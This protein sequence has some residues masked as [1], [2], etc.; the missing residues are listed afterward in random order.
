MIAVTGL[1]MALTLQ[2]IH[3]PWGDVAIGSF[4]LLGP[5]GPI[6]INPRLHGISDAADIEASGPISKALRARRSGP[7][8]GIG[9]WCVLGDLDWSRLP[10]ED[11]TDAEYLAHGRCRRYRSWGEIQLTLCS[12]LSDYPPK[13]STGNHNGRPCKK[14]DSQ[15]AVGNALLGDVIGEERSLCV[16]GICQWIERGYRL[17]PIRG[18]THRQK[19][20]RD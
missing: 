5:M 4:L 2:L 8:I 11:Q 19:D 7:A 3:A 1:D 10:H 16:D 18:K 12:G 20:S 15:E 9:S 17:Q 13:R 6:L 14:P